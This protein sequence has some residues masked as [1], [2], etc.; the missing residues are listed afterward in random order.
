MTT[1][2]MIE[3][4]LHNIETLKGMKQALLDGS[5]SWGSIQQVQN[6]IKEQVKHLENL[7]ILASHEMSEK[8]K[9]Q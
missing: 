9:G 6:E 3:N 4:T 7:R 2:E 1:Q 5:A 8:V